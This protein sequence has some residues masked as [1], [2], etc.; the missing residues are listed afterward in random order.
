MATALNDLFRITATG[1]C[2]GQRIMLTHH[3]AITNNGGGLTDAACTDAI[4]LALDA[5]GGDQFES[6]YLACLPPQYTLNRWTAQKIAPVRVAYRQVTRA[7]PGAHAHDTEAPNQQAALT[8]RC[9]LAGRSNVG[10]KKIGPLPQDVSVQDNRELTAAYKTLLGVL[11]LGMESVITT[12]VG[13]PVLSPVIAH[14]AIPGSWTLIANHLV[15]ETCNVI[16][17]RTVGR[18]I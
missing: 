7:V 16:R 8:F 15:G 9:P 10:T 12:G 11:A 2:F 6:A 18:G 17:R 1:E 13:N 5:T 3:Y 4:L 14:P